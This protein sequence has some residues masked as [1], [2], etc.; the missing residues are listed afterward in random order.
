MD[1][2]AG[3]VISSMATAAANSFRS[4]GYGYRTSL[5]STLCLAFILLMVIPYWYDQYN[6][7]IFATALASK[8]LVVQEFMSA[9]T[10]NVASQC[11]ANQCNLLEMLSAKK[12]IALD[13]VYQLEKAT[14]LDIGQF[15]L[16][17]ILVLVILAL[18][19]WLLSGWAKRSIVRFLGIVGLFL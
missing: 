19:S 6:R 14:K 18:F 7:E 16:T 2:N 11:S 5:T 9:F 8:N 4:R 15:A 17:T 13:Y 1:S 10:S 12:L 3:T